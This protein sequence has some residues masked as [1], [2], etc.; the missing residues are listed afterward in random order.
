M[1]TMDRSSI[2]HIYHPQRADADELKQTFV[3]RGALLH[4]LVDHL[5]IQ[6][7]SQSLQH[8]LLVGP[9]GAGK[10]HL[11]TLLVKTVLES[12]LHRV[13]V[14]G[15]GGFVNNPL[16]AVDGFR[17]AEAVHS[18]ITQHIGHNPAGLRL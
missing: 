16:N 14:D 7:H 5:K 13:H 18:T 15:F 1:A 2:R 8:L 17:V 11:V 12:E 6:A 9:R 4:R 3:A 10:T